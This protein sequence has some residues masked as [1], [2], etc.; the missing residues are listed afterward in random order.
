M[1]RKIF[2]I[3]FALVLVLSFSLVPA[4]PVAAD[5]SAEL[6]TKLA[7]ILE[8]SQ[9]DADNDGTKD[10]WADQWD[11][12]Q[13]NSWDDYTMVLWS[14]A[15]AALTEHGDT[16]EA[17]NA[18]TYV[19]TTNLNWAMKDTEEPIVGT[20]GS[21]WYGDG[22]ANDPGETDGKMNSAWFYNT[23][24][25]G[26]GGRRYG[27]E[28]MENLIIG[29]KLLAEVG[30]YDEAATIA[31]AIIGQTSTNKPWS[32]NRQYWD[33]DHTEF[34]DWGT[35]DSILRTV[36]FR[37]ALELIT[38][39][40]AHDYST[41][42]TAINSWKGGEDPNNLGNNFATWNEAID[43]YF[44]GDGADETWPNRYPWFTK[45]FAN[46]DAASAQA[47]VDNV[48]YSTMS[49]ASANLWAIIMMVR[50]GQSAE[51]SKMTTKLFNNYWD[52]YNDVITNAT[53]EDWAAAT[54][55]M[56][57]EV[58]PVSEQNEVWVD[59]NYSVGGNN[60]GHQ[61]G[62]DAFD[63]I[64]AAIDA[65]S[66]GYTVNVAAGT[67]TEQVNIEKSMTIT[68]AGQD[69][70]HIVSPADVASLTIYD[71]YGSLAGEK[72]RFNSD[73]GDNIPLVRIAASDVTFSGFHVNLNS[74]DLID[75]KTSHGGANQSKGVGILVDYVESPAGGGTDNAVHY[76][77]ITVQNNKVDG[78]SGE[79]GTGDGGIE[80][81]GYAT[82]SILSNEIS[83]YSKSAV[84]VQGV[85]SPTRG[86]KYPTVTV[87]N[88]TIDGTSTPR[89]KDINPDFFG[90]GFWSG[91]S[92]SADGNTIYNGNG[93]NAYALNTWT[94]SAVSF[95]NNTI[96]SYDQ[97]T[98]IG[99]G[100]KLFETPDLIFSGNT[101]N[102]QGLGMLMLGTASSSPMPLNI[103]VTISENTLTGCTDG[104]VG[105]GLDTGGSVT[106]T[107][108]NFDT[109]NYAVSMDAT[110]T[111]AEYLD[112]WAIGI[113]GNRRTSTITADAENNWWGSANGP[114]DDAGEIN[115]SG[116]AISTNVDADP[117]I[118]K[119][120]NTADHE[121]IAAG[122][123]VTLDLTGGVTGGSELYVDMNDTK[124]GTFTAVEET[125]TPSQGFTGMGAN[126]GIDKTIAINTNA[127]DGD[128]IMLVKLYYTDAELSASN[129]SEDDLRL[130]YWDTASSEWELAVAGNTAGTATWKGNSE[131]PT[132]PTST[133][134]GWHGV[135][136]VNNIAWAVV[137]HTTE[138]GAGEEP[139]G[140]G[141]FEVS[142]PTVTVTFTPT[143]MT[144]MHEQTVTVNVAVDS[145]LTL[146]DLTSLEFKVWYD[147]DATA[148]FTT[149]ADEDGIPDD[150]EDASAATQTCAIITWNGTT[151]SIAPSSN[152]TWSSGNSTAPDLGGTSGDFTLKFT[153]GKVATEAD[154][155]SNNWQLAAS[156]A[157]LHGGNGFGYDAGASSMDWYGSLILSDTI[158]VDWGVVPAGMDFD[159]EIADQ[160]L[161]ATITII[162]NGAYDLKA[163]S[164]L[165]WTG[166]SGNATL[167]ADGI[168][169]TAGEFALKSA[170]DD[171]YLYALL[172]DTSGVA[173]VDGGSATAEDGTLYGSATLWLKLAN[174]FAQDVYSGTITYMIANNI[175]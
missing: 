77:G 42:I 154:G 98:K 137:D 117:W 54:L 163:K 96:D 2:S 1:K 30:K 29:V 168:C 106:L 79:G 40:S 31:D 44:T 91:G 164:G 135:D 15:V 127:D 123:N 171:T 18:L 61:W 7:N 62:Y 144:P 64:Q 25:W 82:V 56:A 155:T 38:D 53:K 161:S 24:D 41:E 34:A 130:C 112:Y 150:F 95:T 101:I 35:D 43:Y 88:N 159:S 152:T 100:A 70:T 20:G 26:G 81:I 105:D 156:V 21:A 28:N 83:G 87:N 12:G 19:L 50:N 157:S 52:Y 126:G 55:L 107:N 122:D 109:S 165:T 93:L 69:T 160:A 114:D 63:N 173:I 74:V 174:T 138:Y 153:P 86:A 143:S 158:N 4:V 131:P 10:L 14:T 9:V 116:N 59:D 121:E 175:Y 142:P 128:F 27:A 149:D 3:L 134:L 111:N 99:I 170:S 124:T 16:T 141:E 22:S 75:E 167:D 133:E 151:F 47:V 39:N 8:G 45:L 113:A 23:T 169:T 94:P 97:S 48:A 102:N 110:S 139:P 84:S 65:V 166:A 49:Y 32:N 6:S 51:A 147:S 36:A 11:D 17:D 132:S 73:R 103:T 148:D 146:E 140:E 37:N 72:K 172:L 92:G 78:M 80:V 68:G 46:D 71:Y 89:V 90:I 118:G 125:G 115:G 33:G 162:S 120:D 66:S 57:N 58:A 76:T 67:Y 104:V 136:Q 145:T 119:A 108:N 5:T 85:D 60:D 129:V 13:G